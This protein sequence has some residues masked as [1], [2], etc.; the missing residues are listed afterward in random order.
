[1]NVPCDAAAYILLQF[2]GD[3]EGDECDQDEGDGDEGDDRDLDRALF[4]LWLAYRHLAKDLVYD[5]C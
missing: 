5:S 4:E 1:M 2:C 3:I